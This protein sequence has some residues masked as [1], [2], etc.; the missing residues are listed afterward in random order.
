MQKLPAYKITHADLDRLKAVAARVFDRSIS[1][2]SRME[3]IARS[4]G[5]RT[6]ASFLAV[7]K[8]MPILLWGNQQIEEDCTLSLNL[9]QKGIPY[10]PNVNLNAIISAGLAWGERTNIEGAMMSGPDTRLK[11]LKEDGGRL[12]DY[13]DFLDTMKGEYVENGRFTY[14]SSLTFQE[15]RLP[16]HL[17]EYRNA[18][19]GDT[20]IVVSP[21][22]QVKL[23]IDFDTERSVYEEG[24]PWLGCRVHLSKH[25]QFFDMPE[26]TFEIDW[27]N[28]DQVRDQLKATNIICFDE[29]DKKKVDDGAWAA[30]ITLWNT[31]LI[32]VKK[33]ALEI[34][35]EDEGD[36]FT[37]GY[38][39]TARND[40]P[41]DFADFS[42]ETLANFALS[43]MCEIVNVTHGC[44]YEFDRLSAD[45]APAQF[46]RLL[47][48]L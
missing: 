9:N 37:V 40:R 24:G 43:W 29:D 2:Q 30:G 8:E 34:E 38:Y 20:I 14:R 39:G 16:R 36:F 21:E 28:F 47:L 31:N 13:L 22:N 23:G 12:A 6:Y 48:P 15:A 19:P 45:P 35:N 32:T 26:K 18:V 46:E 5:F 44:A 1:P 11:N 25:D 10:I 3:I 41:D 4:A 42:K 27:T 7:L 33:E 17:L